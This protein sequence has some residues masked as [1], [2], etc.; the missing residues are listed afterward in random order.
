MAEAI[1]AA[2]LGIATKKIIEGAV[3]VV[4]KATLDSLIKWSD[5]NKAKAISRSIGTH[6]KELLRVKTIWQMDREVDLTEIFVPPFAVIDGGKPTR[7]NTA[8][9]INFS[10]GNILIEG[11]PGHGKSIL[12]RRLAI[13][14]LMYSGRIPI[15]V[16]LRDI[17]PK[18][19]L[20]D[21]IIAVL[22]DMGLKSLNEGRLG[23]LFDTNLFALFLDGFDE[24]QESQQN[25]C[26]IYIESIAKQHQK[27]LPIVVTTRINEAIENSTG[28]RRARLQPLSKNCQ[29]QL[30][31][32]LVPNDVDRLQLVKAINRQP[33]DI[34]SLLRT[35]LMMVILVVVFKAE[36]KVP[37]TFSEF[38]ENLFWTLLLRHDGTKPGY[39]RLRKT[40][41][42]ATE[43]RKLFE[44][45]C[46][47]LRKN[48]IGVSFSYT[49]GKTAVETASKLMNLQLESD[50]YLTD[51]KKVTGLLIDEDMKSHFVHRTI[52]EYFCAA[53]ITSRE[54]D[55]V[56][57][58]YEC[59]KGLGYHK[60]IQEL[61][62]LRK[63]DA[64][65]FY[66]YFY[67]DNANKLIAS[68]ESSSSKAPELPELWKKIQISPRT[69]I[70]EGRFFH[71]MITMDCDFVEMDYLI[72]FFLPMLQEFR[73]PP[74]AVS[75]NSEGIDP[76]QLSLEPVFEPITSFAKR[77]SLIEG[78][79]T[80]GANALNDFKTRID[81]ANSL[82]LAENERRKS[83]L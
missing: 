37:E 5:I 81:E 45:F 72:S 10:D 69:T 13:T 42:G 41:L 56:K 32:K 68:L 21:R 80:V 44:A 14:C 79:R 57:Q 33:N 65:R 28:F 43:F 15:F 30:L 48:D 4:G 52:Q 23:A 26:R 31:K 60:W 6:V 62:F 8:A 46:Y 59:R 73:I 11:M 39:S 25:P 76:I 36:R 3:F 66:R 29:E 82:I 78:L 38:Y 18:Q 77:N 55:A 17:D 75:V 22:A 49:D 35:P 1:T 34:S 24:L 27:L 12:M 63:L 54:D 20:S 40:K 74:N 70:G 50:D 83:L 9:D 19:S 71:Y 47:C 58:F 64:V 51:V 7:F 53:Y 16:Q 67:L 61:S 2:S